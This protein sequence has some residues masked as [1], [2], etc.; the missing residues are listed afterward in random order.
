MQLNGMDVFTHH[1]ID[2]YGMEKMV[3]KDCST[4]QAIVV[5]WRDG[6]TWDISAPAAPDYPH[7]QTEGRNE[8]IDI[9]IHQVA[10]EVSEG[11]G[12]STQVPDVQVAENMWVN[13]REI[14]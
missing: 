12:Y 5:A 9:M 6:Q 4:G 8:A 3:L 1:K 10:L 7:V 11:T 13:L 14:P 2:A